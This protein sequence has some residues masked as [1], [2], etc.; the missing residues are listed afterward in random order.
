[1][2]AVSK[3]ATVVL[4]DDHLCLPNKNCLAGYYKIFDYMRA[5][6]KTLIMSSNKNHDE[7]VTTYFSKDTF[8]ADRLS[9]RL[10]G[11]NLVEIQTTKSESYATKT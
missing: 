11:L 1:M 3:N 6:K 8:M 5:Y 2:I 10:E 9:T 7:I 4:M